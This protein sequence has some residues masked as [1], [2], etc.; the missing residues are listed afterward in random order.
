MENCSF[1][2][3]EGAGISIED[4]GELSGV[5]ITGD[6]YANSGSNVKVLR[7]FG[8][9]DENGDWQV[10]INEGDTFDNFAAVKAAME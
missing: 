4:A 9:D 2:E 5:N 3:T 1:S 8:K 6:T 10:L 7:E